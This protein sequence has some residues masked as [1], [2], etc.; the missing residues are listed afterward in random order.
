MSQKVS[1]TIHSIS[2]FIGG[3]STSTTKPVTTQ[4]NLKPADDSLTKKEEEMLNEFNKMKSQITKITIEEEKLMKS[5]TTKLNSLNI[6]ITAEK[7]MNENLY[8]K[9][10]LIAAL[11]GGSIVAILFIFIC[12]V[13]KVYVKNDS[14]TNTNK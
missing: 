7:K 5:M 9:D 14:N 10:F 4:K 2:G 8:H 3:G 13:F 1:Q 12:G 11:I 6:A